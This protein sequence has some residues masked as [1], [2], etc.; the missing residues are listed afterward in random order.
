MI[1]LC[2]IKIPL[3]VNYL[4]IIDPSIEFINLTMESKITKNRKQ[5]L[6]N[7]T[8]DYEK[9]RKNE[10]RI[11]NPVSKNRNEGD[12]QTTT[13][14]RKSRPSQGFFFFRKIF[15]FCIF[16]RL[17]QQENLKTQQLSLFHQ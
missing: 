11:K 3:F 13:I 6:N 17:Y 14:R 16:S 10:Y 8:G 15:F 9:T 1:I 12:Y 5:K 4:V 7:N 2:L